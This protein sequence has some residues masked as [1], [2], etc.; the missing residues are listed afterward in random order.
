M[1]TRTKNSPK[2]E[3]AAPTFADVKRELMTALGKPKTSRGILHYPAPESA[4]QTAELVARVHAAGGAASLAEAYPARQLC[5][6]NGPPSMLMELVTWVNWGSKSGKKAL[7]MLHADAG[8]RISNIN[9]TGFVI[10]LERV[11]AD[12][13]AHAKRL[14]KIV[15]Q[16]DEKKIEA[17]LKARRWKT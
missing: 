6:V 12:P 11:P 2:Q 10:K 1:A 14:A 15:N 7:D 8:V 4:K 13:A 17:A 16:G 5:V 9:Y 3:P